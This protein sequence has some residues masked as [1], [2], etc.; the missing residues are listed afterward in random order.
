MFPSIT[1]QPI[2]LVYILFQQRIVSNGRNKVK[3]FITHLPVLRL[4]SLCLD[5]FN[6]VMSF[7]KMSK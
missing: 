5:S 6:D 3:E 7:F 1:W 2:L 4:F